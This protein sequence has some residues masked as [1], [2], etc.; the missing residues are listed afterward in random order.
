[1]NSEN[2]KQ[3]TN[4]EL[5]LLIKANNDTNLLQHQSILQSLHDFHSSTKETLSRIECQTTKT[6]GKVKSLEASRIQIWTAISIAVV[7]MGTIITLSISAIDAKI[8]KGI[9]EALE[10]YEIIN[11]TQK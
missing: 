5:Y 10:A 8:E 7:F 3:Y 9:T 1:M 6:N 11:E 4:R 2:P